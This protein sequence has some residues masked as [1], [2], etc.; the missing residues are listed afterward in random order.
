[1]DSIAVEREEFKKKSKQEQEQL[2]KLEAKLS[3]HIKGSGMSKIE[4]KVL[5]LK[6]LYHYIA[7]LCF[8]TILLHRRK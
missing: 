4:S 1:M 7:L 5:K 6:V 8:F 3:L 2:K